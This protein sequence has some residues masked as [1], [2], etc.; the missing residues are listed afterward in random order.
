M[1]TLP[2]SYVPQS[3]WVLWDRILE[4]PEAFGRDGDVAPAGILS[5]ALVEIDE[6]V[7]NTL[8][9]GGSRRRLLPQPAD[10]EGVTAAEHRRHVEHE[11]GIFSP[12]AATLD[13][14][15]PPIVK[16]D[17]HRT[18]TFCAFPPLAEDTRPL[19]SL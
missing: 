12:R 15:A 14:F 2:L 18:L 8:N 13:R 6:D 17:G 3:E 9:P 19:S 4:R 5:D 1:G 11:R 16:N 10:A 7:L